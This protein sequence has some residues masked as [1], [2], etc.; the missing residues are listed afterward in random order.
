MKA[1]VMVYRNISP[2]IFDLGYKAAFVFLVTAA[3]SFALPL[4]APDPTQSAAEL[5]L[6]T[7][8]GGYLF[9]WLN[10][11]ILM[12][13]F[14]VILVAAGLL[15]YSSAPLRAGAVWVLTLMSTLAFLI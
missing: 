2:A 9:G 7:E 11:V 12:F 8:A 1:K 14:A 5:W 3:I 13:A 6:N 10:Q 15:I 4:E